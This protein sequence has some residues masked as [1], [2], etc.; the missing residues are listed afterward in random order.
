MTIRWTPPAGGTPQ[1]Y[2]LEAGSAPGLANLAVAAF[3]GTQ[4]SATFADVL[5]G[6]YYVRMRSVGATG[7]SAASNEVTVVVTSGGCPIPPAPQQLMAQ[8]IGQQVTLTW[9]FPSGHAT[10]FDIEA[11]SASGLADLAILRLDG[12]LPAFSVVAPPGQYY[13]RVR[14]NNACA[15]GPASNETI[16]TVLA[17]GAASRPQNVHE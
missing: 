2:R 13:V 8:V 3:G 12:S 9:Q 5:P 11:G 17:A 14:P 6:T 10:T 4:Q 7:V 1:A 16:V 15:A